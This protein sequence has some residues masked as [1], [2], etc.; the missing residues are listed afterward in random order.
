MQFKLADIGEGTQEAEILRWLV[1]EGDSV[2]AF[3][4]LVEVQTDKVTAELPAPAAGRVA[5][6]LAAAGTV[7]PVG[8]VLCEIETGAPAPQEEA[9][10][11]PAAPPSAE[12]TPAPAAPPRRRALASPATRRRARELGVDLE[13][14]PGSGPGGRVTMADV[15]AYA[16]RREATTPAP[17]P[18]PTAPAAAPRP[19]ATPAEPER[20]PLRGLRRV[21]ARNMA[22]SHR[23]IPAALHLDDCDVTAL[24]RLRETW[25]R[26]LAAEGL[27]LTF[28][29]ILLKAA[30]RTL[31]R[32]PMLNAH[33]DEAA[34]AIVVFPT[35]NIGIATD[36]P[37]GLVV[38]VVRD[39]G[40]LDLRTIAQEVERLVTA[41]RERRLVQADLEGGTFTV[42]N[43]GSLGGLYGFPILR[44]PEVAILG[45]GRIRREPVVDERG[46]VVVRDI[47][48]YSVAFDHR[49]VDGGEVARFGNDLARYLSHPELLMLEMA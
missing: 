6:I 9:P 1:A 39:V 10:T 32:H 11:A 43:H 33:F 15:E 37:E 30:A 41:A 12:P 13:A 8:T 16:K 42:T 26:H 17:A 35:V 28:L 40:R 22:E 18:R 7:V 19:A 48:H 45:I 3:Q 5:R 49:V 25:N 46:E 27:H 31:A 2:E 34:D 47:L 4:P 23:S 24:V 38:P 14:V 29:P 21:I 20:I 44:Q 36:T